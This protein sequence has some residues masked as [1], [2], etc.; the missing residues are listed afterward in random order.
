MASRTPPSE[1]LAAWLSGRRWYATKTRRIAAL[2][3]E[4]R[5]AVGEATLVIAEVTL[6]DGSRD[7]YALPLVP[8]PDPGQVADALDDPA[9]VR[10]VVELVATSGRLRGERGELRGIPTAG[11]DRALPRELPAR[12]LGGEQSN[13]S[14]ALG[15]TLIMKHFRRLAEGVN[16]EEEM[17]RFLTERAGFTG[18][19]RL[20]GHLEY[21][22]PGHGAT[23]LAV[24]QELVRGARDGW[25]W[26][27]AALGGLGE[28]APSATGA[29]DPARVRPW[30]GPTLP[31]LARLG[32]LTA[33]L[34]RA[35]ASQLHDPLFAPA[36]ITPGDIALWSQQVHAQLDAALAVLGNDPLPPGLRPGD[37]LAGLLGCHKIRVHGDFHLGQ[38]LYR[39]ADGAWTIIDFEGEP[40]R[41]L[42]E[43]R[44]KHAPAR[45]VAGLLRSIDYAAATL[46]RDTPAAAAWATSWRD[47][48][49]QA[50]LDAYQAGAHGASFLPVTREA[51]TRA[52]AVFELEKAAYEVVYE[53]NHRPD[54]VS[55]PTQGLLSA[56]ARL[57]SGA[58]AGAA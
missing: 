27:C 40:L 46:V 43:R 11:F 17:T 34:H 10:A 36:P 5:V 3:I 9:F 6:D 52:I 23:T 20:Y 42:A 35:L 19:P 1:A 14:V 15:D 4:D 8:A 48:A 13:T 58:A 28:R 30:S 12:R 39:E 54:W 26:M 25:Q 56:S 37:G 55:I 50:F 31:A 38:T 57:A 53:A 41:S 44:E 32:A 47:A 49:R 51:Q 18:T 16:P 2:T 22:A 45:D 33:A 7:R 29:P 24:V 21:T